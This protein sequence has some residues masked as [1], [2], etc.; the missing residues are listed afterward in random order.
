MEPRT[1]SSPASC[2]LRRLALWTNLLGVI[3]L[4]SA[5]FGMLNYLSMRHYARA[6][7]SRDLFGQLSDKS[8]QILE[9]TADDIRIVALLRPSHEAYRSVTA[10]LQEYMA[11]SPNVSVVMVDPDRD[12]ARTE[13]LVRQFQLSGSECVVFEIGGR[14]LA[15]S[16]ADLIEYGSPAPDAKQS[17]RAFRG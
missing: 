5:I 14:H 17:R 4:A 12:L 9:S 16:A 3:L 1:P 6:H 13:Q 7:W 10:L 15:V 2:R 8:I 11:R